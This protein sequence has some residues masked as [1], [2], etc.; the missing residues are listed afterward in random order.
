MGDNADG[1]SWASAWNELSQVDWQKVQPGDRIVI[2]GGAE[3]MR[4][5]TS[6][7]I[8]RC[9]TPEMPITI[10]LSDEPGRNGQAI[11]FG[12]RDTAL[13]YCGQPEYVYQEDAQ[14]TGIK[15]GGTAN[16]ILD[17]TKWRG[18][19]I[20]GFNSAGL[21]LDNGAANITVRNLE[22]FDNGSARQRDD[23]LWYPDRP[24]VLLTGT[25]ILFER[26]IIH[27]NGADSFQRS[28]VAKNKD[29]C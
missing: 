19:V 26:M 6:L 24:G 29:R 14:G 7:T 13:P 21:R 10:Q 9:G 20:H 25:N 18:I 3:S 16:I 5:E 27:D 11:I 22:I 28:I 4:Y 17:G 8:D 23:A 15:F 2:D 1:A 12:G